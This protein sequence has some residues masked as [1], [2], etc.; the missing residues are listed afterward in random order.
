[1]NE[2]DSQVGSGKGASY[3]T[4]EDPMIFLLGL[5][6]WENTSLVLH[7]MKMMVIVLNLKNKQT[8][9]LLVYIPT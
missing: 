2:I 4:D 1:M 6:I 9:S 5:F 7:Q 3:P 8:K